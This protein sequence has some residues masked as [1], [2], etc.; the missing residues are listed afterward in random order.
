MFFSLASYPPPFNETG[1][2]KIHRILLHVLI[3]VIHPLTTDSKRAM[4]YVSKQV[5][6][7]LSWQYVPY[8]YFSKLFNSNYEGY[9]LN[10]CR[11]NA[12]I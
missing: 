7:H 4:I 6:L 11:I 8:V 9:L 2:C 5:A 12:L 3:I 1:G 10:S